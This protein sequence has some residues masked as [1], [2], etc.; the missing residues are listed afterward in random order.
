LK[1][2]NIPDIMVQK[3]DWLDEEGK[4]YSSFSVF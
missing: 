3:L 4:R 1:A 2:R